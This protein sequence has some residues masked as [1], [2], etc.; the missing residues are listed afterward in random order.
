MLR[1]YK[2]DRRSQ[3]VVR[4]IIFIRLWGQSYHTAAS[5]E[6]GWVVSGAVICSTADANWPNTPT[7]R[8]QFEPRICHTQRWSRSRVRGSKEKTWSTRGRKN[9]QKINSLLYLE[10][11]SWP[12]NHIV[13]NLIDLL[14][15]YQ[16]M[17]ITNIVWF[18]Q[19]WPGYELSYCGSIL[20]YSQ[21]L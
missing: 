3:Y 7:C 18:R 15:T 1:V 14:L 19:R 21:F 8:D 16:L 4:K 20:S 11:N 13:Q 2:H 12:I 6:C 17:D 10:V 5:C 9:P